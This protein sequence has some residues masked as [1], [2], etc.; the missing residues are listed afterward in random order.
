[1]GN[2]HKEGMLL[3][4][5]S[6]F[7]EILTPGSPQTQGVKKGDGNSGRGLKLTKDNE[8]FDKIS[9]KLDLIISKNMNNT[10]QNITKNSCANILDYSTSNISGQQNFLAHPRTD[11]G[12]LL[13]NPE[14]ATNRT[15]EVIFNTGRTTPQ[16]QNFVNFKNLPEFVRPVRV[17]SKERHRKGIGFNTSTISGAKIGQ[18]PSVSNSYLEIGSREYFQ[19]FLKDKSGKSQ[20]K[21]DRN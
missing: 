2:I 21:K 14:S 10:N 19:F 15:N 12:L 5:D 8:I 4:T 3:R 20:R 13:T 16:T 7:S 18:N 9:S 17:S 11:S 1:L 6:Q